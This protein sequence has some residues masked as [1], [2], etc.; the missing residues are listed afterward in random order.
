MTGPYNARNPL[1]VGALYTAD[2]LACLLPKRHRMIEEDRPLRVLVANWGHL[3]DVVTILPLLKFLEHH[4]QVQELGVLIGSWS[5]SVLKSSDIAARI[6]VI[7]H[8]DL[9]RSNKSKSRKITQY[10]LR[11]ISL[12]HELSRVPVRHVD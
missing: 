7:D 2:A 10:L 6:H 12:V 4:P 3:G 9:D 11:R 5:R 8:W 1:L